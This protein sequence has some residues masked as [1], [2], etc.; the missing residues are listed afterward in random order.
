[1][2]SVHPMDSDVKVKRLPDGTLHAPG[3]FDDTSSDANLLQ[4][5]RALDAAKITTKGD[6]IAL[7]TVQEELGFKGMNY[8]FDQ[9]PKAADMIVGIDTELGTRGRAVHQRDLQDHAAAGQRSGAGDL[10]RRHDGRWHGGQRDR[11]GVVVH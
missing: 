11:A 6:L 4:M 9:N 10:Q 3:V 8:W 1:M 2:D 5:L 7:F